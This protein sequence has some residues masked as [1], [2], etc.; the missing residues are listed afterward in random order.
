MQAVGLCR[1]SI[2]TQGEVRGSGH[3]LLSFALLLKTCCLHCSFVAMN[4][5]PTE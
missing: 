4:Q 3:H 1:Y 5:P 2:D